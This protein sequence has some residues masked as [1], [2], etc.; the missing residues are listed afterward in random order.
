[1]LSWRDETPEDGV[2]FE[3]Q[4]SNDGRSFQTVGQVTEQGSK[5]DYSFLYP[6]RD[7]GKLFFRLAFE[8]KYSDVRPIS[9]TCGISLIAGKQLLQIN[10]K[11]AGE[12]FI[13]NSSGQ[14]VLK[15]SVMKGVSSLNLQI[16]PGVY[17]VQFF[18]QNGSVSSQ[19]LFIQ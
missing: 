5:N 12:I 2:R 13:N 19:K 10:T 4:V 6:N 11:Q 14:M 7:C 1:M 16:L 3:V 9:V 8:G 15:Q 17:F 18:G